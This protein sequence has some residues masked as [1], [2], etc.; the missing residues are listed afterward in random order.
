M[1][2]D[3]RRRHPHHGP[4]VVRAWAPWCGSCRAQAPHVLDI[5][6]R[7]GVE[8]IDVQVD[9]AAD[10]TATFGI[11]SVPTLI[12]LRDG[13]EVG[14]LVGAQP[15]DAIESLFR[16]VAS[17]S[18]VVT[19]RTP[20]SLVAGRGAAGVAVGIAGLMLSSTVLVCVGALLMVWAATA[21]LPRR[22][23]SDVHRTQ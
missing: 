10:T 18:G 12:G 2:N 14:R 17:G 5:A 8:L 23:G 16:A 6:D 15:V 22:K 7:V 4:A 19:G 1:T 21:F 11:H 3:A 20:P 9:I 13:V